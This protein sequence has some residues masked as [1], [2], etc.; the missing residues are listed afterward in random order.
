LECRNSIPRANGGVKHMRTTRSQFLP[1]PGPVNDH[2]PAVDLAVV[3]LGIARYGSVRRRYTSRL[4]NWEYIFARD[5][6]ESTR[7][8][9]LPS[10]SCIHGFFTR[11]SGGEVN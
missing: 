4:G 1:L 5:L 6:G 7:Q 9:K 3:L 2:K 10:R 8:A 11:Y